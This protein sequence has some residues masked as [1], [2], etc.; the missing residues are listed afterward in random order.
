MLRQ[1]LK[2]VE[3]VRAAVPDLEWRSEGVGQWPGAHGGHAVRLDPERDGFW[4]VFTGCWNTAVERSLEQALCQ[5]QHWP[6]LVKVVR[7][8]PGDRAGWSGEFYVTGS[9]EEQARLEQ[10]V[11][12]LRDWLQADGDKREK[13]SSRSDQ[14]A[15]PDQE[16]GK[17]LQEALGKELTRGTSAYRL[18][19]PGAATVELTQGEEELL[20]RCVLVRLAEPLLAVAATSLCDFLAV[21]NSRLRGCR[22][23][24]AAGAHGP[25]A[26][27]LET[28]VAR[29]ALSVEA[30]RSAVGV[31]TDASRRMVAPCQVLCEVPSFGDSYVAFLLGGGQG[32]QRLHV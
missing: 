8:K 29:S 16:W 31:L 19:V 20:L 6:W 4:L 15:V 7:A 14:A 24:L 21:A 5:T 17:L 22:A 30:V 3:L 12:H 26:A 9:P 13:A 28:R 2:I 25:E 32:E 18:P 27:V 11:Q 23:F 1:R 10:F